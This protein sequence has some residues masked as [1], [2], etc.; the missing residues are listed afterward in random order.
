MA[1]SESL[2][3]VVA[4]VIAEIIILEKGGR[5]GWNSWEGG[6]YGWNTFKN[7][8]AMTDIIPVK[9]YR[10]AEIPKGGGDGGGRYSWN[11]SL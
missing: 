4:I 11:N 1:E 3:E 7:V 8:I 10:S 6:R 5:Y 2:L 9:G